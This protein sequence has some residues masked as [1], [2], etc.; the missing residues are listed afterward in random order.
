[1]TFHAVSVSILKTVEEKG[2]A[3]FFSAPFKSHC[4]IFDSE[5]RFVALL[6]GRIFY[7]EI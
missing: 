4:S 1:M 5:D 2:L 6:L 7:L 3:V